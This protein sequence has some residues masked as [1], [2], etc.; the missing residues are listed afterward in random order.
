VYKFY[1]LKYRNS[2]IES[3]IETNYEHQVMTG[4]RNSDY[5]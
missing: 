5:E 1:Q 4:R 3:V 2:V